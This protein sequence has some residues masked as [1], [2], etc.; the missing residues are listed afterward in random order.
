MDET[1]TPQEGTNPELV[2]VIETTP[3]GEQGDAPA[4]PKTY[5]EEQFKQVLGRAKTAEDKLKLIKQS[6]PPGTINNTSLS[7]EQIEEKILLSQGMDSELIDELKTLAKVRK[8]GLI[9]AQNDPI[10]IAIKKQKDDDEKAKKAKLGASR[11]SG[12]VKKEKT[13][14]SPGLTDAEHKELW[15]SQQKG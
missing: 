14:V 3:E 12:T 6:T 10:F 15:L 7:E 13:T 1:I 4:Q 2:E 11:G 8:T 9:Q 5:T